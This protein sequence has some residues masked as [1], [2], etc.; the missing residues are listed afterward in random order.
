MSQEVIDKI[1]SFGYN[2]V[3]DRDLEENSGLLFKYFANGN[4]ELRY[5]K[6]HPRINVT[7]NGKQVYE[8]GITTNEKLLKFM[9]DVY[10]KWRGK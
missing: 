10:D 3:E 5:W 8:S 1:K 2:Q 4:I 6:I 7:M 9:E